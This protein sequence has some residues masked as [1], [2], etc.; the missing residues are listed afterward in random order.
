V[1]GGDN[2]EYI[3]GFDDLLKVITLNDGR[4]DVALIREAYALADDAHKN[5]TRDSGEPYVTHP[6]AVAMTLAGLGMDSDT[7][8]AGLLHDVVED[9]DVSLETIRRRF[10]NDVAQLVDGVTKLRRLTFASK[11]E[12]KA[13]N[14]RKMLMAIAR[15]IRVIII[16]LADRLHNMRTIGARPAQKQRDTALETMEV[17]A[18]IAHRLGIRTIQEELEDLSLRYLDP[19][20]YLEIERRMNLEKDER[21]RFIESIKTKIK[22]RLYGKYEDV[23][24]EGRVKS[25]YGIFTKVYGQGRSFDEIYDIYAVRVIVNT[26]DECYHILG[27]MHDLF[28]PIPNRFKDYI[29]TPK[30]NQY[31]SLHTTVLDKAAIPFEVQIRT[32]EMHHTAEYGIASHWKYKGGLEGKDTLDQK[33]SWVRQLLE[34]QKDTVDSQDLLFDIKTDLSTDEVL[35]F[36]PKGDIITLP[37]G[38]TVIDFAYAIHS[39]IGNRM[40]GAKVDGKMAGLD[41]QLETGNIVNILTTND[42]AHGPSRDWLKIVKT[43]TARNRIRGWFRRER[44]EENIAA[45]KAEF[46]KELRRYNIV[47]SDDIADEFLT[48]VARG[49]RLNSVSEFYAAIGFGGILLSKVMPRIRELYSQYSLTGEEQIQQLVKASAAKRSKASSGV[50]VEGLEGCL[51]KYAKCCNPLPGD[52]I[53]G[54][55]TRGYGVSIH[56]RDCPNVNFPPGDESQSERLVNCEWAEVMGGETFKSTVDVFGKDREGLLVDIST[57]LNNMH[58]RVHSLTTRE[59]PDDQTAIQITFDIS[60]LGQLQHVTG[61][62]GRISGISRVERTAQ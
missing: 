9:T 31:Q 24:I 55:I 6:V 36:T 44:K 28:R 50:I 41:T 39:E 49:Q 61:T 35:A 46:E 1:K 26:V 4:Y 37:A 15:D 60:D 59:Q 57:A 8:I 38:S 22:E 56:K 11:E 29:S 19:I 43:A 18:P 7:L 21:Q 20:A 3:G 2:V 54:Y 34:S 10:G 53:K 25:A 30:S 52:P 33:I 5:Q 51:V 47:L 14:V 16:K 13:E 40:T 42:R 12:E 23:F 45:G 27:E 62:L 58:V 17:Y 48:K 32:W